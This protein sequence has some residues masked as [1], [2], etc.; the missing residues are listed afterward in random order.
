MHIWVWEY[1]IFILF[2]KPIQQ[3]ECTLWTLLFVLNSMNLNQIVN[4]RIFVIHSILFSI[5]IHNNDRNANNTA[6]E[7]VWNI[8]Y[9][10][11]FISTYYF[12]KSH[13]MNNIAARNVSFIIYS[14]TCLFNKM[15][16]ILIDL[17]FKKTFYT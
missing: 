14:H 5:S 13:I 4:N 3:C 11:R 17:C 16:K 12:N 2:T 8:V 1:N 6:F 9:Y 15:R 7:I 10:V